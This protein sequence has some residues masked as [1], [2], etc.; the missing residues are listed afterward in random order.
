MAVIPASST[1]VVAAIA[2]KT[3]TVRRNYAG[4]GCDQGQRQNKN[5][6]GSKHSKNPS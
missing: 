1:L 3:T 2:I 6:Y 5:L 4:G